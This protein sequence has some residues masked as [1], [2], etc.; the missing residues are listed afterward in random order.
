MESYC[1]VL[2]HIYEEITYVLLRKMLSICIWKL[3]VRQLTRVWHCI[4]VVLFIMY[5]FMKYHQ[6]GRWLC[7]C[8]W[9]QVFL[10]LRHQIHLQTPPFQAGLYSGPQNSVPLYNC[11]P[12]CSITHTHTHTHT[13]THIHTHTYAHTHTHTHTHTRTRTRTRTQ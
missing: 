7:R 9:W 5:L 8:Q 11:H 3:T 2:L 6:T 10:P 4:C 1:K 13:Y 12:D